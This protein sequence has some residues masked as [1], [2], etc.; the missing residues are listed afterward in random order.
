MK[1]HIR[2]PVLRNG[3]WV[4]IIADG[5]GP[6]AKEIEVIKC[7]DRMDAYDTYHRVKKQNGDWL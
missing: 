4:V 7:G 1:R 6:L 2:K 5:P 3:Q